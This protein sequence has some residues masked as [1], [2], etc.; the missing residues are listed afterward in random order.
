MS[1]AIELLDSA[2]Q[3]V[4][5]PLDLLALAVPFLGGLPGSRRQ[6]SRIRLL[7]LP[8][9]GEDNDFAG[10]PHLSYLSPAIGYV[11]VMVENAGRILYRHPHTLGEV[12]GEGLH[13]WLAQLGPGQSP[14]GYRLTGPGLVEINSHPTPVIEGVTEIEPY[15]EGEQPA[16]RIRPLPPPPP[17]LR[18]LASLGAS[19]V[20]PDWPA[21]GRTD[22]V[23]V[24]V[25]QPV[26]D[27]LTQSRT[28]STDVE[29]GGFLVGYVY[30]D[31]DQPGTY[32][33]RITG[34]LPARQTGASF[35]HFTFTGDSFGHVKQ[36]L[37]RERPGEQLLG[38]Y[39]T[40][41]FAATEEVGLSSIDFR[42]HFTTFRLPW[43]LAG[44]INLNGEERLL[45]FYVRRYDTMEWCPHQPIPGGVVA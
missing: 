41:L 35:L 13:Q 1:F 11:Q 22:F 20:A 45:R 2:G 16:F 5:G 7:L 28:F 24:L 39:H 43:Q 23:K 42:L 25:E 18:S 40:H 10:E 8:V 34:A 4:A 31:Q 29:E 6:G 15:A 27:E 38:W 12:I 37:D 17:A 33:A 36:V 9:P 26:Y 14:T 21:P 3:P 32:L 30:E 44:L 19:P